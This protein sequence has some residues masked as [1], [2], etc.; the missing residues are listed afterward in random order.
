MSPVTGFLPPVDFG[1]A[2]IKHSHEVEAAL[3]NRNPLWPKFAFGTHPPTKPALEMSDS[4]VGATES[5]IFIAFHK[6]STWLPLTSM[7]KQQQYAQEDH[8]SNFMHCWWAPE[9]PIT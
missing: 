9:S 1:R 2:G 3:Q 8:E 6:F 4:V 7:C 5:F